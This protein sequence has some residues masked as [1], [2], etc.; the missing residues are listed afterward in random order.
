MILSLASRFLLI[1][2][3][4]FFFLNNAAGDWHVPSFDTV[5][6]LFQK[7]LNATTKQECVFVALLSQQ[8]SLRS[9]LS[10]I[11][12]VAYDQLVRCIL[13]SVEL[14]NGAVTSDVCRWEIDGLFYMPVCIFI[15]FS[16]I[17]K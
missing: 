13:E 10:L 16:E 14:R 11:I 4:L 2:L 9:A 1:R 12:H 3:T 6:A 17:K 8:G 15:R 7:L 5:R